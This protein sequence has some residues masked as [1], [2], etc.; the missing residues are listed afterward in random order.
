MTELA[1]AESKAPDMTMFKLPLPARYGDPRPPR[2]R[3][4]LK[5]PSR[6][7]WNPGAGSVAVRKPRVKTILCPQ[8]KGGTQFV[9]PGNVTFTRPRPHGRV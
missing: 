1:T 6:A 2:N 4:F 8:I 9:M 7:R 5:P 3:Q